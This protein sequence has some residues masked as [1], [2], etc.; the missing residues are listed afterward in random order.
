[1]SLAQI[2][3]L[4]CGTGAEKDVDNDVLKTSSKVETKNK[5]DV[6]LK[7][8]PTVKFEV[9]V[10][11]PIVNGVKETAK[12]VKT[13]ANKG[14]ELIRSGFN[15]GKNLVKTG[16]ELVTNGVS[17]TFKDVFSPSGATVSNAPGPKKR[18]LTVGSRSI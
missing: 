17:D 6:N 11:K 12:I 1:M 5:L 10:V 13:G 4:C 16:A 9:D 18:S 8:P 7:S 3:R 2:F 15:E 14:T